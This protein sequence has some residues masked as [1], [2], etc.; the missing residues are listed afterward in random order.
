[1]DT[2]T[3]FTR[4]CPPPEPENPAVRQACQSR[5]FCSL[6]QNHKGFLIFCPG[7]KGLGFKGKWRPVGFHKG[8]HCT[9]FKNIHLNVSNREMQIIFK[10]ECDAD[11]SKPSKARNVPLIQS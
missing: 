11:Y 5:Q 9:N 8:M 3:Q 6:A 10:F 1:M 4:G 7:V 2:I